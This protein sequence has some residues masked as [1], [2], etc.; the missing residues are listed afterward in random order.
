M[1]HKITIFIL[2]ITFLLPFQSKSAA[3]DEGV[4][5]NRIVRGLSSPFAEDEERSASSS[6]KRLIVVDTVDQLG[7]LVKSMPRISMDV[8]VLGAFNEASIE[9]EKVCSDSSQLTMLGQKRF[10][11][12]IDKRRRLGE[13]RSREAKFGFSLADISGSYAYDTILFAGEG[14]HLLATDQTG[15][16]TK[17]ALRVLK[18]GGYVYF[19]DCIPVS[20]DTAGYS[21]LNK[22]SSAVVIRH[23]KGH[24]IPTFV[25]TMPWALQRIEGRSIT[26]DK[27]LL[28]APF[29]R[30]CCLDVARKVGLIKRERGE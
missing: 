13:A 27:S 8:L 1:Q 20:W 25:P 29:S 22:Y 12:Y 5:L 4:F 14:I 23:V 26:F 11:K 17:D 9:V 15:W 10:E 18:P 7:I 3:G 19:M 16:Y 30:L 2:F 28:P 24:V 6:T 21:M